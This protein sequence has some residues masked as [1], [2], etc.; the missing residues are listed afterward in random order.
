MLHEADPYFLCSGRWNRTFHAQRGGSRYDAVAPLESSYALEVLFL[1]EVLIPS[2]SSAHPPSW[3][4]LLLLIIFSRRLLE[5]PRGGMHIF[6]APLGIPDPIVF[7]AVSLSSWHPLALKIWWIYVWK[8]PRARPHSKSTFD[9]LSRT[10]AL[11]RTHET[12]SLR[13][14]TRAVA[15]DVLGLSSW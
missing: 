12:F 5:V 13:F 10:F 14:V 4:S 2:P 7:A 11:G 15:S 9:E 8:P 1:F 3:P 6:I